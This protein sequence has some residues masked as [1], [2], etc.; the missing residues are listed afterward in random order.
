MAF[1]VNLAVGYMGFGLAWG[2]RVVE[3]Y[4]HLAR[5]PVTTNEMSDGGAD[6]VPLDSCLC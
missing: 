4:I 6:F 1:V 5:L 2:G 3:E